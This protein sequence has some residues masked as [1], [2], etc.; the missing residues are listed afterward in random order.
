M[1]VL[2][3]ISYADISPPFCLIEIVIF[4]PIEQEKQQYP[5][6]ISSNRDSKARQ[7]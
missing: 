4:K 6:K 7:T 2:F 1:P 3:Q 5:A